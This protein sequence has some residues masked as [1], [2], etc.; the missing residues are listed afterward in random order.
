MS[1]GMSMWDDPDDK[2]KAFERWAKSMLGFLCEEPY[3]MRMG[4][5]TWTLVRGWE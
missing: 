4:N 2:H 3:A 1:D 5:P